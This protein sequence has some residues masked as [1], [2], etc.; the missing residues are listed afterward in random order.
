MSGIYVLLMIWATSSNYGGVAV[1]QQ[2][3]SSFEACEIAR[4][5]MAKAHDGH[6]ANLRAQG[7][8]RKSV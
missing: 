3:F 7:C 1:V 2:E 8:F 6:N 4:K 5:E